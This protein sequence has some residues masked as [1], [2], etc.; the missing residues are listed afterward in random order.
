[1]STTVSY[2]KSSP[3]YNSDVY[4]IFLDVWKARP[5]P[6]DSTDI[7][8]QIDQIY[9]YRPDLLA[10]DLYGNPELWWIFAMRNPDI[11]KD[12]LFDFAVGTIIYVPKK[13][14]LMTSLG[15]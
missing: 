12:P 6:Y 14:V 3:Y 15:L 2:N 7:V 10:F 13:S 1:M 4:G 11:I 5:I 8:Y 9:N